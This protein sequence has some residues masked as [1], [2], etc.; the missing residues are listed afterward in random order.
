ML[1][2][3]LALAKL[4]FAVF[5]LAHHTKL[6]TRGSSGV[7]DATTDPDV[8][9]RLFET[10]GKPYN[11]ALAMGQ[12]SG[13]V[14]VD[15]DRNHGATDDDLK[16]LPRTVTVKTRNGFHVYFKITRPCKS[17]A[18]WGG[19]NE[20]DNTAPAYLRTDG[21]YFVGPGSVVTWDETKQCHLA[22]HEYSYHA[23]AGGELSF[24]DCTLAELPEEYYRDGSVGRSPLRDERP[25]SEPELAGTP[26]HEGSKSSDSRPANQDEPVRNYEPGLRHDMFV[27]TAVAMRKRG[28]TIEEIYRAV[29]ERNLVDTVIPKENAEKEIRNLCA[30]VEKE[31]KPL[32]V[33]SLN[34]ITARYAKYL[35]PLGH[36]DENYYYTTSD[37]KM[38]VKLGRASHTMGNLL[39]L[40]PLPYWEECYPK[41]DK[42]GKPSGAN[43]I[44]AAS[45]LMEACRFVGIY[46]DQNVRGVGCWEDQGKLV[47]HTGSELIVDG[48]LLSL[49]GIVGTHY[50]YTLRPE[51]A[52]ATDRPLSV[53]ECGV[54]LE[55][56]QAISWKH[57]QSILLFSGALALAR[58]CGALA[59]R[60]HIW[61]TGPAGCGKSSVMDYLTD[62]ILTNGGLNVQGETT[63]AGIR[64]ALESDSK[65]VYFDEAET[66][67]ERSSKRMQYILELARQ[68]SFENDA[69]I[70]KGTADGAG[71]S[72]K[73]TSMFLLSSVRVNL[74]EETDISRFAVLELAVPDAAAWPSVKAKLTKV[75]ETYGDRLHARMMKLWPVLKQ[76]IERF[77]D[78]VSAIH[79]RRTGQQYGTLLAGYWALK[80]DSVVTEAEAKAQAALLKL[81]YTKTESASTDERDCIDWLVT[82]PVHYDHTDHRVSETYGS[83]INKATVD[84]ALRDVL[85]R[86]GLDTDGTHLFVA[87]QHGE[88]QKAYANTK[89]GTLFHQ[90]LARLPGVIRGRHRFGR[91]RVRAVSL[92]LTSVFSQE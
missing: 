79:D 73:I 80:S 14:G 10:K 23:D 87:T 17:G 22:P 41:K 5:P 76:N 54:L 37:N 31:I 66:N 91:A 7:K 57:E 60:P 67:N 45:E 42:D 86:H 74:I 52:K 53:A 89:W 71:H 69:K 51:I 39:D 26:S 82:L 38:I 58:L 15:L 46:S 63:S 49:N 9:K 1:K 75:D 3:A 28:R 64:Q 34:E 36:R 65:P 44:L 4:G 92:P 84:T 18:L 83:L 55:A 13:I 70:L 40:M 81:D 8:I 62:A 48:Q 21:Q 11:L 2:E 43:W 56:C 90:A 88:L 35:M 16:R 32:L 19:K 20:G 30:W 25:P 68:A 27:R 85:L 6:P 61:L 24:D 78:A 12:I 50:L 47:Y 77:Q 33:F 59:W 72:Y 29:A